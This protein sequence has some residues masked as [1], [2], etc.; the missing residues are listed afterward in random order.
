MEGND[1]HSS[2]YTDRPH[3]HFITNAEKGN[4]LLR[5]RTSQVSWRSIIVKI[6]KDFL[7]DLPVILLPK[8]LCTEQHSE[9][10]S[11][12]LLSDAHCGSSAEQSAHWNG[13]RTD[14]APEINEQAYLCPQMFADA[15]KQTTQM[16]V[17]VSQFVA[18][19]AHTYISTR[20]YFDGTYESRPPSHQNTAN[21]DCPTKRTNLFNRRI[22][23]FCPS[24][25]QSLTFPASLHF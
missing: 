20:V 24:S 14:E 12:P 7:R 6:V 11:T 4:S 21:Y 13:P 1:K 8:F 9:Q 10:I 15:H 25:K 3:E 23:F 16:Y 2:G 18:C 19:A 22:S 17:R 5:C